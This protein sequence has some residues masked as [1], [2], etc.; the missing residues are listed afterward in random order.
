MKA[1]PSAG[2]F[3]GVNMAVTVTLDQ[4]KEMISSLGFSVP[5]LVAQA[6]LDEVNTAQECFDKYG[7]SSAIQLLLVTYAV[8]RLAALSG[9]AKIASQHA[10]SGASRS[11]TYDSAGTDN[12]VTQLRSWDKY[13]CLGFLP[14]DG[15]DSG[16]FL[17]VNGRRKC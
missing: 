15:D 6:L 8:A 12:L 13:N 11:F 9:S 3:V 10:P 7:Y 4:V 2:F 17:V 5:D 14:L 1:P 16:F